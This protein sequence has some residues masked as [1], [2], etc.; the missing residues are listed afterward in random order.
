MNFL[1]SIWPF[2]S[3]RCISGVDAAADSYGAEPTSADDGTDSEPV[4]YGDAPAIDGA[5]SLRAGAPSQFEAAAPMSAPTV[6]Q[7]MP[8]EEQ[9]EL[10]IAALIAWRHGGETLLFAQMYRCHETMCERL[11]FK[12]CPWNRVAS[13]FR[14][15][16]RQKKTYRWCRTT[17]GR[18][19]R[20][21][22]F[23]VPKQIPQRLR[24]VV[25]GAD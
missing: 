1:V 25:R 5:I 23:K 13:A 21:A 16:T 12:P 7:W 14:K 8:P 17:D 19:V 4:D 6:G 11:G 9:A 20:L 10:L 18:R 15:L 2:G 24:L 22:V 3:R